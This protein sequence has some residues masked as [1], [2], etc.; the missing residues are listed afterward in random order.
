MRPHA[1]GRVTPAFVLALSMT[2]VPAAFAGTDYPVSGSI[3]V[4]GTEGPLPAGGE[5][6]GSSYDEASGEI[7]AGVFEFPVATVDF[8]SPVG[9]VTATYELTQA[10][11][12]SGHVDADGIA[13]LTSAS[14]QLRVISAFIGGLVPIPIGN[15]CVF[16]PIVFELDGTGSSAGLDLGDSFTIPEVA[17]D[18]CGGFG[19]EINE[20]I[21]GDT[22]SIELQI[23]GDFT[24]P[25]GVIDLIFEDGFD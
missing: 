10:D 18:A 6:V 21:A 19:A 25:S 7:G 24:P 4:N 5:F 20:G 14:M 16:W 22:N 15:D 9:A 12:S 11:S 8:D 17:A 13:G 3:T 2:M 23:D 1:R